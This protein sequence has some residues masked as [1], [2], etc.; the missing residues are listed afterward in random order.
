MQSPVFRDWGTSMMWNPVAR[1]C[2]SF[3]SLGSLLH[4]DSALALR[5]EEP[6]PST[7]PSGRGGVAVNVAKGRKLP[8]RRLG[9][10]LGW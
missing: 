6:S 10:G 9:E 7:E 2:L 5:H 1:L 8:G 3:S 4:T